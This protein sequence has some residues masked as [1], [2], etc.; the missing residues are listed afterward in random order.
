MTNTYHN[1]KGI[2]KKAKQISFACGIIALILL[3]SNLGALFGNNLESKN[4]DSPVGVD[5][6]KEKIQFLTERITQEQVDAMKKGLQETNGSDDAPFPIIDGHGTGYVF[7][8]EEHLDSLVGKVAYTGI[9][10]DSSHNAPR[11]AAS[12][13]LLGVYFP[14]VGDQG[15]QGSCAAWANVY[16]AYGYLEAKDNGWDTASSGNVSCLLSPAWIYNKISTY[17]SGSMPSQNV[18]LMMDWGVSTLA[19]LPYDDSTVEPWGNET[20]WREAPYHRPASY[21]LISYANNDTM[22]ALIK[23]LLLSGTPVTFGIDAYNFYYGGFN[24]SAGDYTLSAAEYDNS[25]PFLNHAQCIVGYDDAVGEDGDVGAFRVVNSWGADWMDGGYYWLTYEA[26]KE[27]TT[28]YNQEI[29]SITDIPDYT[30]SLIAT[31]EFSDSPSRMANILTLGVGDYYAPLATIKPQYNMEGYSYEYVF[32]DF[33]AL[34]IS[35]F[36]PQYVANQNVSFYVEVGSSQKTGIISSFYVERYSGGTFAGKTR[37]AM[38]TPAATPGYAFTTFQIFDHELKVSLEL[39]TTPKFGYS[40][41]VNAT[42]TNLGASDETGVLLYLYL[43]GSEVTSTTIAIL[44]A[45]TR[46][47]ITYT[48]TPVEYR[49]LVFRVSSPPIAEENNSANNDHSESRTLKFLRN[50]E[51]F[52]GSAYTWIDATGGTLV[53]E[54]YYYAASATLPF[55]FAFYNTSFWYCRVAST[56]CVS[57]SNYYIYPSTANVSFPSSDP[58]YTYL[59]APFWDYLRPRDDFFYFESFENYWVAEWPNMTRRDSGQLVGSFELVL[60][61]TGEIAFNY[62]A[63][64]YTGGGYTCGLNYGIDPDYYN[65]YQ[66]LTNETD[67]F[68]ILFQYPSPAHDLEVTLDVPE[69]EFDQDCVITARVQNIGLNAEAGVEFSLYYN[70]GEVGHLDIADLAVGAMQTLTLTW[71]PT[72]YD[73]YNFTAYAPPVAGEESLRN[74]LRTELGR[75]V[76]IKIFD[77]MYINHTF[78]ISGG[79][80]DSS[81]AYTQLSASTFHAAWNIMLEGQIL[82]S[83][84]WD[85]NARTRVMENAKGGLSFGNSY[86]T[87]M[88]IFN[89]TTLGE[90][91]PIAVDAEGD[92]NFNVT[93]DSIVDLPGFGL[94]DVWVLADLTT[95]GGFAWY[96]KGSGILIRGHFD[97]YGGYYDYNFEFAA[98]N[99][100]M[101]LIVF[102]HDLKVT[103]D[104]PEEAQH[105]RLGDIFVITA[106]VQNIGKNTETDVHLD[107][108]CNGNL[109]NQTSIASFPVGERKNVTFTWAP[110]AYGRFN[111]TAVAPPTTSELYIAN[112]LVERLLRVVNVTLF[113]GMSSNYNLTINMPYGYGS[114]SYLLNLLYSP[115]SD[116][117]FHIDQ[118]VQYMDQF[119]DGYWDEEVTTRMMENAGGNALFGAGT[120][121]PFWIFNTVALGE[122]LPITVDGEGDR[123]FNVTGSSSM[124]LPW[125]GPIEVWVLSDLTTPGSFAWYEKNSGILVNGLFYYSEGMY[126]YTF[127][128]LD[129]NVFDTTAPTWSPF[130][131]DQTIECGM[132]LSYDVGASDHN[133]IHHYVINDTVRFSIDAS[134]LIKNTVPLAVGEYWVEIRAYD[135]RGNYCSKILKI[136]VQAAAPPT[137]NPTPVDQV[138]EYGNDLSYKVNASDLSGIAKYWINDTDRFSIDANGTI[139]NK[140]TLAVGEYGVEIR[141]YD[142]LGNYCT[143]IIKIT[144]E[145]SGIPGYDLAI[146]SVLIGVSV[147]GIVISK[148][149]KTALTRPS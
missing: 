48:W 82:S 102:D 133:G 86:H 59:I 108:Y 63:V 64:N 98:T 100:D 124:E 55:T 38:N 20:A 121:T 27:T 96:E 147:A 90:I 43:D 115:I 128:L 3:S 94:A 14:A 50:Y 77:G 103:L 81:C 83:N 95:P 39:P 144:V 15:Q 22:I 134:G 125:V 75:V 23:A 62:D 126:N 4:S 120:H 143:A 142:P 57:F 79:T 19:S 40:Y 145:G 138:I 130:P 54:S 10:G 74:N 65:S 47:T 140:V 113:D 117:I 129:S 105:A 139:K 101:T 132:A 88:W 118:R 45:E 11:I 36:Q 107:L 49:T 61:K 67:D 8:S 69:P 41:E 25:W 52:P 32:P 127:D 34:D 135:A 5:S 12:T 35:D 9:A 51:M 148:R 28:A 73:F 80:Y 131:V 137:W 84:S 93:G 122:I 66:G 13:S 30:P 53:N 56:G 109:E 123:T 85:V 37:E 60:Y 104:V 24:A 119:I 91:I 72:A 6:H 46:Y 97:Y 58:D 42:V 89:T 76:V 110:T 1:R 17:D 29:L 111:F 99:A 116:F 16:Y 78:S 68:S 33:I 106:Q 92:H 71:K 70:Q 21:N 31:W 2:W 18:E 136:Q 112:N 44:G 149:K 87:P 26:F 7:S 141:A 146:V 114:I